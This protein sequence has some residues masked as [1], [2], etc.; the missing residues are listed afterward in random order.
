MLPDNL[1]IDAPVGKSSMQVGHFLDIDN[2][3]DN[4]SATAQDAPIIDDSQIVVDSSAI[5]HSSPVVQHPVHSIAANRARR[6]LL[7]AIISHFDRQL[8]RNKLSFTPCSV[9]ISLIS[10]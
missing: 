5:A 6:A 7:T 1:S 10:N 3:P 2:T 4:D 8:L 9:H